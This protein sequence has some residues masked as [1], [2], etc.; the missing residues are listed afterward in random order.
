MEVPA[1]PPAGPLSMAELLQLDSTLLPALER[2]QLRLL[3]HGL[4]SLQAAAGRSSGPLPSAAELEAWLALQPTL[5]AD[6][7]FVEPFRQQ[8]LVL[9]RQLEQVAAGQGCTALALE[10]TQLIAWSEAE[11]QQRLQVP[12]P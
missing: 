11:A 7:D 3:A 12:D 2:H 4:R 8:L 1:N 10:L 5:Q 9:G 6:P